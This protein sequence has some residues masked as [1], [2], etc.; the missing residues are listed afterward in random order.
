M[1]TLN[2]ADS[3]LKS[4]YLDAITDSLNNKTNYFL[5]KIEQTTQD[6]YGKD[7]R[8]LCRMGVNGGIAAG[9]ETGDLPNGGSR[10]YMTLVAP[11]KNIYGTIEISDK[12]LR[13][14][15]NNEGA[16]VNLLE[17]EM[18]G[19]VKS[20][21]VQF[22]RMLFG[23]GS[24]VLGKVVDIGDGFFVMDSVANFIEGMRIDFYFSGEKYEGCRIKFV[25]RINNAIYLESDN[26][27]PD[28]ESTGSFY[29]YI[30]GPRDSELCGLKALFNKYDIYGLERNGYL[31]PVERDCDG[32][33]SH[34]EMQKIIDDIEENTGRKV[35]VI[36]CSWGVR[37]TIMQ[38]FRDINEP[39]PTMK[40]EDG[41][42][43]LSYQ[44]IPIIADRFCPVGQMYFLN[45]ESFK[46]YQ[47]CD[48]EWLE[49]EDGKILKQIP[50][51]PVYTATLVKY[52]ELICDMPCAQGRLV[53]VEEN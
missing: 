2:S 7:V 21:K 25:D 20:A 28:S 46:I 43:A 42:I 31:T 50:G 53:N 29:V 51:K 15:A 16:L 22:A 32:S 39:L 52:A 9:A 41:T 23:D 45:T 5:S 27:L 4:F 36:L 11:L 8:K 35:D 19:L 6:V 49:T 34:F 40:L 38:H 13:A 24:G 10:E 17:S 26:E 33:F 48:W 18:D 3:A 12:A 47:L 1:V 30:S 37:R 14:A 44:G